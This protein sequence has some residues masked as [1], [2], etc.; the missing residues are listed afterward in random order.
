MRW[1]VTTS[2]GHVLGF[3]QGSVIVASLDHMLQVNMVG[4]NATAPAVVEAA[5]GSEASPAA[6]NPFSRVMYTNVWDGV[7][8][9]YEAQAGSILKSTYHVQAGLDGNPADQIRLHYNRP[10]S[11]DDQGNLVIAYDNGTMTDSVPVAWQDIDGQRKFVEVSYMLLGNNEVGF[12]LG[13]YDHSRQLV[14][15]PTLTWNTFLGGAGDD[16][17]QAVAVDGSG[18]VYVTGHSSAT[19][20]SPVR[21]FGGTANEVFVAKLNSSGSLVW[22]TFL[23]SA[24]GGDQASAIAVD[25]SS[26]VYVTG[27]SGATWGS[28]VRAFGGGGQDLFAAKLNSSGVLT[29][30]TFLGGSGQDDGTGIAVDGSGNVYVSGNSTATWGSPVRAFSGGGGDAFAAKLNSSG[31]LTWNTFLGGANSD[32]ATAIAVDGSGNAYVTGNSAASWGSPVR[33]YSSGNDAFAAKLTTAGALVWNTF[34]GGSGSD[35]GNAIA[36]DA[37]GS[38]YVAGHSLATWG[39]PVEA[40]GGGFTNAM[41]V[42]LSNSGSLTWNT[43]L[44]GTAQAGAYGVAIGISG[45]VHVAGRANATWGSPWRAFGGSFD[46]FTSELNSSGST[47]SSG[48]LGG[49][50]NDYGYGIATDSGGNIYVAGY[51]SA[52]WG[53][54]VRVYSGASSRSAAGRHGRLKR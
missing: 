45:N 31:G 28:P 29:W 17:G 41:V 32:M 14:I 4:A 11:L 34:L 37:G 30:N 13:D 36:L 8:A 43:F 24:T 47:A 9:V 23:G 7:T 33:A 48:F 44:G 42:K 21:A 6:L 10:V 15:D 22:N 54:P 51:S 35:F 12:A 16:Y 49:S 40:Y 39:S 2:S 38:I 50:G 26:N 19:W 18:N 46:A 53:T 27:W 5:A 20:G 3:G 52:T 25:G 1:C